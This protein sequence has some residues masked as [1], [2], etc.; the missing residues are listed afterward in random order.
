MRENVLIPDFVYDQ[1]DYYLKLQEQALMLQDADYEGLEDVTDD[2]A[3]IR[4]KNSRMMPLYSEI[5]S[6]IKHMREEDETKL[7]R[8][9]EHARAIIMNEKV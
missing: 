9:Y 4:F 7:I 8:E 6:L 3:V 1:T 2:I 5:T